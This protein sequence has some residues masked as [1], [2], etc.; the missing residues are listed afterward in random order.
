MAI[1]HKRASSRVSASAIIWT[2]PC[3][4]Y[5][6]T[7]LTGGGDRTIVLYDNTAA[8]GVRVE[9]FI[10]DGAKKTDGHSHAIPIYCATGIYASLTGGSINVF[11]KPVAMEH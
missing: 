9:D 10:A 6:F 8:S 11:F 3:W 5:G 2:G 1:I 4:Y 7:C